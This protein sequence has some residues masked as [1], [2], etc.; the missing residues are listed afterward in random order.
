[1]YYCICHLFIRSILLLSVHRQ[2]PRTTRERF[3]DRREKEARNVT[4]VTERKTLLLNISCCPVQSLKRF[5]QSYFANSAAS[6]KLSERAVFK[7]GR[8]SQQAALHSNPRSF[9]ERR[10]L[11]PKRTRQSITFGHSTSPGPGARGL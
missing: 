3:A 6:W 10:A 8:P 2:T 11:A 5:A 9:L 7:Y 4:T 1:M